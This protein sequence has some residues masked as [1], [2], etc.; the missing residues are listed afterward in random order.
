MNSIY[1]YFLILILGWCSFFHQNDVVAQRISKA[2]GNWNNA[3]GTWTGTV[4]AAGTITVALN[5]T[6]VTG[7]GTTFTTQVTV[8]DPIFNGAGNY[9]GIIA[10]I[11][12]NTNLVLIEGA[13]VAVTGAAYLRTDPTNANASVP[14]AA[15]TDVVIRSGHTVTQ[16]QDAATR[17]LAVR[18][19]YTT[20]NTNRTLTVNNNFTILSGG[21]FNSFRATLAVTGT[22]TVSG[23]FSDTNNNGANT[24]NST[25]TINAG[26][27]LDAGNSNLTVT[28]ATTNAGTF[29][30][31]NNNGVTQLTGLVTNTGTWTTTAITTTTNLD[32]RGGI[33]NNGTFN[34]GAVIFSTN[35][36]AIAGTNALSFANDVNLPTNTTTITLNQAVTVG[37]NLSISTGATLQLTSQNFTVTGTTGVTGT[38]ND[39]NNA[40]T[41]LFTGLVTVNGGGTWNTTAVTTTGNLSFRNGITSNGTAFSAGAATFNTNNQALNGATVISFANNV[42]ITGG[43]NIT[44]NQTATIAGNL[45]GSVA[46]STWTNANNSTLNYGGANSPM[47]TGTFTTNTCTNTVNYNGAGN[48]NVRGVT[49]CNLA[50]ATGGTKTLLANTTV[51]GT[52][53]IGVGS[54]LELSTFN[55][56]VTGATTVSGTLNDNSNA[57]VNTFSSLVTV[58]NTGAWAT[59]AVTTATNLDFRNGITNNSANFNANSAVFSTNSQ[60]L[61]GTG[62]INFTNTFTLTNSIT[63]TSN[64]TTVNIAGNLSILTAHTLALGTSAFTVTGTTTIDGTL[65]FTSA[66]GTK[67]FTGSVTSVNPATWNDTGNP[68]INFGADFNI[69]S[70]NFT[71]GTG[72]YTLTN[73]T[74]GTLT[75]TF[76]GTSGTPFIPTIPN[77]TVA[78]NATYNVSFPVRLNVNNLVVNAGADLRNITRIDVATSISGTGTINQQLNSVLRVGGTITNVTLG[79]TANA[80]VVEYYANA[81]QTVLPTN[82]YSLYL[83]STAGN[84]TNT[85]TLTTTA[86]IRILGVLNITQ[87]TFAFNGTG[88][89]TL[90]PASVSKGAYGR[91]T[92]TPIV[93]TVPAFNTATIYNGQFDE[94]QAVS[95]A[96]GYMNNNYITSQGG[97]DLT[98]I[99]GDGGAGLFAAKTTNFTTAPT[100]AIIKFSVSARSLFSDNIMLQPYILVTVLGQMLQKMVMLGLVSDLIWWQGVAVTNSKWCTQTQEVLQ[101]LHRQVRKKSQW[102]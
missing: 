85:K 41:N 21:A 13:M 23:T 61:G 77:L 75:S 60:T 80:N 4:A 48:Q 53:N 31:T 3:A 63:L 83:T 74:L 66:T 99:R 72:I 30:D 87:A 18:G 52:L 37:G 76:V 81:N 84:T 82:Y 102:L 34:A 46:G 29:Q 64:T 91:Y 7:V 32:F 62:T 71:A 39:N 70:P 45:N 33:T 50:T 89:G 2:T 93:T 10:S 11:T 38:L 1:K 90:T 58:N 94:I 98:F 54:T 95:S 15:T 12:N 36:Q 26:G 49:Y 67:T 68:N 101:V 100:V 44:N 9:I 22:A 96:N 43:I 8:G 28:G 65:N 55:I 57:G 73:T 19:S 47:A 24:F 78:N 79:A 88:G 35:T 17:V 25:L 86:A 40:G 14:N 27:S 92:C 51:G 6:A 69:N 20:D 5:G 42:D 59:T 16:N 56:S 97:N